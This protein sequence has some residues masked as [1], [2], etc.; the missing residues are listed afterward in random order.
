[1][2]HGL[3]IAIQDDPPQSGEGEQEIIVVVVV[4]AAFGPFIYY[5]M[6]RLFK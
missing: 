3:Q 5:Y 4:H 6:Y 2:H 1:M